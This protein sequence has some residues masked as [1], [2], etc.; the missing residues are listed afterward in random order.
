MK[1]DGN[2]SVMNHVLDAV[3]LFCELIETVHHES[4]IGD[5]GVHVEE[6]IR[7]LLEFATIFLNGEVSDGDCSKLVL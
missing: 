3:K 5:R 4:M 7:Q 6:E 1:N 2:D